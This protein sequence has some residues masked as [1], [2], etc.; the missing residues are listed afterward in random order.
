M[1]ASRTSGVING[2][3]LAVYNGSNL[4][5]VSTS[6]SI[7]MSADMRDTSN[8][9]TAGWKKVVPGQKSWT[10]STE[11]LLA[12]SVAYNFGYLYGLWYNKTALTI[13]VKSVSNPTGDYYWTGTAYINSLNLTAGNEQNAT[14]SV[15]LQGDGALTQT[16]P[17]V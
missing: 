7:S 14:F 4:I 3:D 9:D 8:K 17:L 11:A 16:D 2:T 13:Y 5:G 10:V 12:H 15:S 6:C 1:A